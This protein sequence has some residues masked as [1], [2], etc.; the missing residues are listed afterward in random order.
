MLRNRLRALSEPLSDVM[1]NKHRFVVIDSNTYKEKFSFQLT[2]TNAI[3]AI[4]SVVIFLIIITNVLII[5][6]PLRQLIPG[7]INNDM[8]E[9]TYRNARKVDSLERELDRQELFLANMKE[10][11]MGKEMPSSDEVWRHVD[12]VTEV[13]S[14]EYSHSLEDS[15]LRL[16]ISH[17]SA[18]QTPS[19]AVTPSRSLFNSKGKSSQ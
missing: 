12:S 1:K 18:K 8:V 5:F 11:I 4:G 7:Y 10:L 14:R 6:T 15:L 9:Q 19:P 13:M 3:V 17:Q 2:G 16:E